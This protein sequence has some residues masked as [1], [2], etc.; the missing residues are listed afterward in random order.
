MPGTQKGGPKK[1]PGRKEDQNRMVRKWWSETFQGVQQGGETWTKWDMFVRGEMVKGNKQRRVQE[2]LSQRVVD[3]HDKP[4]D[5]TLGKIPPFEEQE[6]RQERL[7][8]RRAGPKSQVSYGAPL[9]DAGIWICS[10]WKKT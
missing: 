7:G 2:H 5:G 3:A 6:K 8:G 10:Y 4:G 1:I 9:R